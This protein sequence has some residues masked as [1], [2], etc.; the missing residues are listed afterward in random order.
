MP[1]QCLEVQLQVPPARCRYPQESGCCNADLFWKETVRLQ[2]ATRDD[3]S[4]QKFSSPR[5]FH[6][7]AIMIP[8]REA[9]R[10]TRSLLAARKANGKPIHR[11]G[12]WRA[13]G[14]PPED[15]RSYP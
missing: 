8:R 7:A 3:E 15:H 13:A 2:S 4:T 9:G 1:A 5:R 11:D 6:A 14:A 10:E 12:P